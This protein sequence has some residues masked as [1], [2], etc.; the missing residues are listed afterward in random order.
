MDKNIKEIMKME[1]DTD[2]ENLILQ[3]KKDMKEVMLRE[4]EPERENTFMINQELIMKVILLI[5]LELAR[6]N[7]FGKT[8]KRT[9]EILSKVNFV[10]MGQ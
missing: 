7:M 1:I 10:G 9:K 8:I 3:I 5:E 4:N 2:M 6:E